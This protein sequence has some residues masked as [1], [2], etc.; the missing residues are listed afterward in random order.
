MVHR[1][2]E[3][4]DL[5][6]MLQVRKMSR[7]QIAEE[8]GLTVG[9]VAQAIRR[10]G[11]ARPQANHKWAV[12]WEV[13]EGHNQS[14][15]AKYLRDLSSLAQGK[16]ISEY[17]ARRAIK[18]AKELVEKGLDI[19]YDRNQP[20]NDE[21]VSGGFYSRKADRDNW[22]VQTVLTRALNGPMR[23]RK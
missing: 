15:V 10:Y 20:P 22:H 16:E 14:K 6:H 21:N 23:L 17:N 13:E 5:R 2:I 8:T 9:G 11:L 18:W 3:P 7:R 12:P 1:R 4:E 19:D